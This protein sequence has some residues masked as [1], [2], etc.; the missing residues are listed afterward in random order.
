[1]TRRV[2]ELG[3]NSARKAAEVRRAAMGAR[4][5]QGH[6]SEPR[7]P[8][9]PRREQAASELESLRSRV[10]TLETLLCHAEVRLRQ[11]TDSSPDLICH[12]RP[13]GVLTFVSRAA[14]DVVGYAPEEMVGRHFGEYFPP[15][16]RSSAAAILERSLA[17]EQVDLFEV[18]VRHRDG[19][20]VL[21]E[22]CSVPLRRDGKVIG[23]Q[24]IARDISRR[25]SAEEGLRVY[26]ERLERV[27]QEG[28]SELVSVRQGLA[29]RL[30]RSQ[31]TGR[32]LREREE[33]LRA[34][35]EQ[36]TIG[37]A[38]SDTSGRLLRVNLPFAAALRHSREHLLALSWL[39][40]VHPEER[41]EA[42]DL[43]RRIAAQE[44][45]YEATVRRYR[46]G[47]GSYTPFLTRVTALSTSLGQ[48]S[49]LL[50]VIEEDE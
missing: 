37:L 38:L 33:I 50:I 15:E 12:V 39:D 43:I 22:V 11:I 46:R 48:P 7:S 20:S 49:H 16:Q 19:R 3:P 24:E 29:L 44:L 41:A 13:D 42:V 2:R 34:A 18:A 40:L 28:D 26:S 27:I 47:D 36:V 4:D 25:R 35:F 45:R 32:L 23:V 5:H 8:D 1:M 21:V 14:A 17:G 30:G 9:A 31:A 10:A 6:P